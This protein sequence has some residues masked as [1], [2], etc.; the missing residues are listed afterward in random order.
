[1]LVYRDINCRITYGYCSILRVWNS[2]KSDEN[3]GKRKKA[4]EVCQTFLSY[5]IL[6][7]KITV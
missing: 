3:E 1:V 2:E 7:Y 5:L 4:A 6:Q